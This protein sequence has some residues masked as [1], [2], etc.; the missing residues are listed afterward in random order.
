MRP[1]HTPW[2]DMNYMTYGIRLSELVA[3]TADTGVGKT[4]VLK[5]IVATIRKENPDAG[6]GMMFLEEPNTD[7]A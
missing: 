4:S 2:D 5:E 1:F 7:T 6:V 3:V